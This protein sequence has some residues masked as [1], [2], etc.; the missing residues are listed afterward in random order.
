M[1]QNVVLFELAGNLVEIVA[2]KA[3][4]DRQKHSG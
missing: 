2:T 3:G 1:A 4:I